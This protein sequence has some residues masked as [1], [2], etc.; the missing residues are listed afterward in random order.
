M[1]SHLVFRPKLYGPGSHYGILLSDNTVIDFHPEGPRRI[2]FE[3]FKAGKEVF[4]EKTVTNDIEVEQRLVQELKRGKL[5]EFLVY[6]C[7]HFARGVIEGKFIS[8]QVTFCGIV[9][10]IGLMLYLSKD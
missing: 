6:N 8:K 10:I 7:E 4:V 2:N 9:G 1:S 3:V 5:Y